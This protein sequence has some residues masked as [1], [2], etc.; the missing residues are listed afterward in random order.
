MRVWHK[1]LVSAVLLSAFGGGAYSVASTAAGWDMQWQAPTTNL[2]PALN[3][4]AVFP[5]HDPLGTAVGAMPGRVSWTW[6]RRAVNWDGNGYWWQLDNYDAPTI[7]RMMVD[8]IASVAG[9][10]DAVSGWDALFKAHNA[11]RGRGEVG[12]TAGEKIAIK[13]NLNGAAEYDDD[14]T[15]RSGDS[16]THPL[17]VQALLL[18]LVRDGKV[19]PENITVYDVTRIVPDYLKEL[20]SQGML[21]GVNFVD[22]T[23]G[24]PDEK[25]PIIWSHHESPEPNYLPTCVTEA[26]YL[27]NLATLKGHNYGITLCAKNHFGSFINSY[28]LRAPQQANLHGNL[29][30][31]RMS[32]YSVLVDLMGNYELG[33]KT[34]LYMLEGLISPSENT[35]T[36]NRRNSTWRQ[37]PFN[38][39]FTNSLFFSQDPVAIDSVGADFLMNEPMCTE[40]N[41]ALRGN[42]TVENYLHEAA[43][44]SAPPSQVTY[45]DGHGHKMSNLGV[46]EHWNNVNDKKY[47]R[48]FGK[49]EGI[50]LVLVD[51]NEREPA[52][53]QSL[54]R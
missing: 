53:A 35:I 44:V 31:H 25:A 28:R 39:D 38:G 46:H 36:I 8:G 40:L 11:A 18:S 16:Y 1:L 32:V 37:P 43:L 22:R 7:Q 5:H 34:M 21:K 54:E 20:C 27:I 4:K 42:E 50:E 10:S 13:A 47:S 49:S 33:K 17:V 12:Y 30:Q 41:Y 51:L 2:N 6:D 9:Q 24:V 19:A 45:L 48:N 23:N 3:T 15:G 14:P 52:T 29:T 26:T